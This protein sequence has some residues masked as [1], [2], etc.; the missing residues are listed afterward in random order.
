M[1]IAWC[2]KE[3]RP[4]SGALAPASDAFRRF[5]ASRRL[6]QTPCGHSCL[7]AASANFCS[8][9]RL[10]FSVCAS[11]RVGSRNFDLRSKCCRNRRLRGVSI[12]WE[13]PGAGF[14]CLSRSSV[15]SRPADALGLDLRRQALPDACRQVGGGGENRTP[16]RQF[17]ALGSTCLVASIIL[18]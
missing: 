18:P 17:S 10:R 1:G 8:A 5:A 15:A 13:Y 3:F 16:V 12:E 2:L 6:F 14:R 7:P 4:G 9:F 11:F